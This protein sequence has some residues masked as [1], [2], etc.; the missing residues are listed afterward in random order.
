MSAL[1][2]DAILSCCPALAS[3]SKQE[4]EKQNPSL[5]LVYLLLFSLWFSSKV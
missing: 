4:G 1:I 2:F 3:P 5:Q